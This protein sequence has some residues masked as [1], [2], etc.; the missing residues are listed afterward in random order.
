MMKGIYAVSLLIVSNI[1]DVC[2]VWA[3]KIAGD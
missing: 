2:M 1:H 3:L